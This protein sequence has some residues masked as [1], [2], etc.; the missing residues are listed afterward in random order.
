MAFSRGAHA[1]RQ[2]VKLYVTR[3]ACYDVIRYDR[4][5]LTFA[6]KLTHSH[7]YLPHGT[8]K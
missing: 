4:D 3:F 8:K 7:F 2:N 5:S 6:E 1:A